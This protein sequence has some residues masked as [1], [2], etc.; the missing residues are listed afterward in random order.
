MTL[1]ALR[2][3]HVDWLYSEEDSGPDVGVMLRLSETEY[4]WAGSLVDDDECGPAGIM[5]FSENEIK[6]VFGCD[7]E[8]A[9][10][11]VEILAPLVRGIS[12]TQVPASKRENRDMSDKGQ[13]KI[14][15]GPDIREA[16][17]RQAERNGRSA[18]HEVEIIL[19]RALA[20]ECETT[21]RVSVGSTFSI[22]Q[23]ED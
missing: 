23:G 20:S 16:L 17:R 19:I 5:L 22:A 21:R 10:K 12:S 18:S 13:M 4:L 6:L 1:E 14:R 2:I 11:L 8:P 15:L 7:Y 9:R 3:G